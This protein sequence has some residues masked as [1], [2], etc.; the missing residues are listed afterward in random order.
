MKNIYYWTAFDEPQSKNTLIYLLHHSNREQ[1]NPN[2]KSFNEDPSWKEVLLNSRANGPLISKP[3]ER[4]YLKP[5]DF[6]PLN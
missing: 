2:W 5:M 4:I 6:S 3:P 1:A